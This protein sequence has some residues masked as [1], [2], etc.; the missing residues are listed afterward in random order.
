M[1]ATIAIYRDGFFIK[2]FCG[3]HTTGHDPVSSDVLEDACGPRQTWRLG[4]SSIEGR[5]IV[6]N[7]SDDV[8]YPIWTATGPGRTPTLTN[9]S[10]GDVFQLNHDLVAGEAV[11]IDA[12]EYAHTCA[13]TNSATVTG[14]GYMKSETCPTCQGTGVIAACATCGGSEICPTCHGSGVI[15]VWVPASTGSTSDVGS[16][17]N[18]RFAMDPNANTFWGFQP[19]ANV[20]QVEMGVVTYGKSIMNLTLVQRY[21]GI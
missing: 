4:Q 13:G 11:V 5:V 1:P 17:Y 15:S 18:L 16:M 3:V 20:I 14:A 6:V 2:A 8:A 19:G 9:V 7:M 21:E 12:T 10:T